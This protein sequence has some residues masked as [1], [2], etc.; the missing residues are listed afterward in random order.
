VGL[1]AGYHTSYFLRS[2]GV[3]ECSKMWG[4]IRSRI[5]PKDVP[6]TAISPQ[7][8]DCYA[9]YNYLLYANGT[10]GRTTGNG[11]ICSVTY[12]PPG[13]RCSS[14]HASLL[15]YSHLAIILFL[16]SARDSIT[17]QI[18]HLEY[19]LIPSFA[20][21]DTSQWTY[22][23]LPVEDVVIWC[24]L[25]EWYHIQAFSHY[26]KYRRASDFAKIFHFRLFSVFTCD[27]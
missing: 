5:T 27:C 25:T 26:T 16:V 15:V 11:K 19:A 10:V 18:R 4:K 23:P 2:D 17:Q 7:S 24:D 21:L 9:V 3:V 6:F 12:P 20:D 14:Y 22:Q 8:G 13:S 1:S